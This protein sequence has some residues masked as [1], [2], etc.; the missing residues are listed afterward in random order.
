MGRLGRLLR[1]RLVRLV[2]AARFYPTTRA[3]M[4]RHSGHSSMSVNEQSRD[5][6]TAITTIVVLLRFKAR[7][8]DR[9][10]TDVPVPGIVVLLRH[11]G[12]ARISFSQTGPCVLLPSGSQCSACSAVQ[13]FGQKTC[14]KSPR[15]LMRE[16]V[17]RINELPNPDH[18]GQVQV[19]WKPRNIQHFGVRSRFVLGGTTGR[20]PRPPFIL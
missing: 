13:T 1:L 5:A 17:A 15:G 9:T 10:K 4:S 2:W 11:E 6:F 20:S 19:K 16:G 12:F 14:Q 7:T 3:T 8:E 18:L